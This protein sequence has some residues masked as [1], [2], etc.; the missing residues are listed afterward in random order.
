MRKTGQ[1]P[2]NFNIFYEMA[3]L[4]TDPD[5][6]LDQV[7]QRV[8][9]LIPQ[10]LQHAG[11][12]CTRITYK[13]E[14]YSTAGFQRTKKGHS[15]ELMVCGEKQG[16]LEVYQAEAGAE[17]TASPFSEQERNLIETVGKLV[18]NVVESICTRRQ[19]E[20]S[21]RRYR[22]IF[23]TSPEAITLVDSDG[24]VQEGNTRLLQWLGY[25]AEEL[26]GI[27][28]DQLPYFTP[29]SR[30]T[31]REKFAQRMRGEK[32]PPY[33]IELV[34]SEGERHV[35]LV[36]GTLVK[37][38]N[39][40]PKDL[41]LITDITERKKAEEALRCSEKRCRTL[42]N[43][44]T[45]GIFRTRSDGAPV[46]VNPQMALMLGCDSP[47][48]AYDRYQ[49]LAHDLYVRP[50]RRR[51][52]LEQI[53]KHGEV[54]NFTYEAKRA[55]GEGVWLSATAWI[56]E[57]NDD[58]S[59]MIDGF[60]QNITDR[61]EAEEQL[62]Q[63]QRQLVEQ[64]RQRALTEMASG[65]AHDFNNSLSTIRGFTDL[66]LSQPEK[67]DDREKTRRYLEL[68]DKAA[69]NAA[70]TVRRMRKF[71]S[72]EHPEERAPVD[73]NSV[74]EEA[75]SMTRPRWE[76]QVRAEGGSIF[77][78]KQLGEIPTIEG[79]EAEL[80][81]VV[82]N[83][84]FNSIRAMP[85][86]GTLSVRTSAEE[87]EVVLEVSDTGVGMSEETLKRCMDPFFTTKNEHGCGLGLSLAQSIVHRHDGRIE[88]ESQ[89]GVGSTFR[90]YLPAAGSRQTTGEDSSEAEEKGECLKVLVVEDEPEQRELMSEYLKMDD[91]EVE[92]TR[93]GY[94][95][96]QAFSEGEYD[97]IIT[98]RSMPGMAG[99]E[100]SKKVRS[101]A[102]EQAIIMLTGFGDIMEATDDMPETVD[103]VLSKPVV[104]K[105]LRQAI[106]KLFRAGRL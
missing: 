8:V 105:D 77:M 49:N 19:I 85:A 99:D 41:V 35:G 17:G 30:K 51:E 83:L 89:E 29:E 21:E 31:I 92:T 20:R 102:P 28:L 13:G 74:V 1:P 34:D 22:E 79:N 56:S 70:E 47:E 18:E 86:G 76:A 14:K 90:V 72:P 42:F 93:N 68:I 5:V 3:R 106:K 46:E 27:A 2:D 80:N 23:E 15:L 50:E 104:L 7:L 25:E 53:R 87:D 39:G 75:V 11:R 73:L 24:K 37:G 81:E 58:G 57:R 82:T 40:T 9:E 94:E 95:G 84:L 45:V 96:F 91:H 36:R 16:M 97:L 101:E 62:R 100:M 44:A 63:V 32:P 4:S 98:D 6:R 61:R 67:L 103:M 38:L 66:L 69:G 88:A 65:I 64:Q 55:D 54:R 43:E 78:H 59:F 71:Y 10:A 48:E 52:F 60:V 12:I 33:E 26:K